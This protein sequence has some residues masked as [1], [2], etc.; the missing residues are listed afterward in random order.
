MKLF[1]TFTFLVLL[2][3]VLTFL[4]YLQQS[5]LH[6][7][8][9]RIVDL[10]RQIAANFASTIPLEHQEKCAEQAKKFFNELGY[11]PKNM[12]AYENH[13]NV[14]LNKCFVV[15]DLTDTTHSPTIW[16]DRNL[17]DAYEGKIYGQYAWH[18]DPSRKHREVAPVW[19]MV[20]L[21]SGE[22]RM[23]KSDEE[24]EELIKVYMEDR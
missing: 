24:F 7:Q 5:A 22:E 6:D 14:E 9:D 15:V 16:T 13:L 2:V 21:P 3:A 12:A 11:R 8:Q 18:T 20:V 23:C 19:C 10:Q 1:A 17:F 4:A